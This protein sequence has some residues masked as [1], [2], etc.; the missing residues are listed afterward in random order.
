MGFGKDIIFDSAREI[1]MPQRTQSLAIEDVCQR[2]TGTILEMDH[3]GVNLVESLATQE[4]LMSLA[5]STNLYAY[6]GGSPWY[7]VVPASKREFERGI[8]DF[9]LVRCPKFEL[10]VGADGPTPLIQIDLITTLTRAEVEERL[11]APFGIGFPGLDQYF[12]SVFVEHPWQ[13]FAMRLDFRYATDWLNEWSSA[14][15][16]VKQGRRVD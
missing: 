13:G 12:R 10:V 6:P 16:L 2:F 4:L 11:P 5:H 9:S 15:W 7:F 1:P 8:D 3:A 14:E